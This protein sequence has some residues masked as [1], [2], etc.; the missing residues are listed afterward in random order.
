MLDHVQAQLTGIFEEL[1]D[2]LGVDTTLEPLPDERRQAVAAVHVPE[3]LQLDQSVPP[4]ALGDSRERPL[5]AD[6]NE[7]RTSPRCIR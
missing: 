7:S 2:D 1:V 5:D 4:A 6:S 3:P